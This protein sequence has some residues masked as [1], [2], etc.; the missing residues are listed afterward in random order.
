MVKLEGKGPL[1][2]DKRRWEN[3]YKID[4][5]EIVWCGMDWINVAKDRDQW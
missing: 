2:I 4:F 1:G 3:I 5:G